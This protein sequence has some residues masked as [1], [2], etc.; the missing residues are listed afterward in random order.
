MPERAPVAHSPMACDFAVSKIGDA[1]V[2]RVREAGAIVTSDRKSAQLEW[3]F[4]FL[5]RRAA[6]AR[7]MVRT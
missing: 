4:A 5:R 7:R 6:R 3:C 2:G 1:A